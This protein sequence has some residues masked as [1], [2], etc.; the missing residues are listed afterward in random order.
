M[1][2]DAEVLVSVD[3]WM[4]LLGEYQRTKT[5]QPRRRRLG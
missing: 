4:N 5:N 3:Q 2:P 1:L